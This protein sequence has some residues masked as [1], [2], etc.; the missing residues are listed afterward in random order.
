MLQEFGNIPYPMQSSAQ[1]L[2]KMVG[3]KTVKL[4]VDDALLEDIMEIL[5]DENFDEGS[6]E[7]ELDPQD[8][9]DDENIGD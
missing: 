7:L 3:W 9:P 1:A 2:W 8:E 5:V 6:M 4:W